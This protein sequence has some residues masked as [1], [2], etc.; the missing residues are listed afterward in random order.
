MELSFKDILEFLNNSFVILL[1][2]SLIKAIYLQI[3][4]AIQTHNNTQDIA[5]IKRF[6]GMTKH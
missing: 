3:K 2:V 5:E 1:A 4:V 6:I